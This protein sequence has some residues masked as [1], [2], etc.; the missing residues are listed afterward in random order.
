MTS[1]QDQIR[2]VLP[3]GRNALDREQVAASQRARLFEAMVELSAGGRYLKVTVA[4]LVARAGVGKPTFYEHFDS[5]DD[6]LVALLDETFAEMVDAIAAGV[7]GELS[8]EPRIRKGLTA[9]IEFV[10]SDVDRARTM[11]VES[12]FSGTA[13]LM[14]LAMMHEMLA[15]FYVSLREERREGEPGEP[16]I[17]KFRARAIVGAINESMAP[18]LMTGDADELRG[19]LE[20]L[21]EV[22]TLL[23]NNGKNES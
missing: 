7:D 5:K 17:S 12:A 21:I 22:V 2:R 6:C 14:K 9:L 1:E 16:P 18:V 13:G 3:R 23:A 20:E 4:D 15:D 19:I 10:A 8:I 11:F